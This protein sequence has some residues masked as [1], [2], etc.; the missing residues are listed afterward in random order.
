M[1]ILSDMSSISSHDSM[2]PQDDDQTTI[3]MDTA[4]TFN[5]HLYFDGEGNEISY[6]DYLRLYHD[7]EPEVAE[8]EAEEED[9]NEPPW[10]RTPKINQRF[11]LKHPRVILA[12]L[13]FIDLY[14]EIADPKEVFMIRAIPQA[15]INAICSHSSVKDVPPEFKPD[16]NELI[17]RLSRHADISELEW[18]GDEIAN[19]V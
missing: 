9:D 3:T 17:Y 11:I 10:I 7:T 8:P 1:D 5:T 12:F 16:V 19:L 18:G 6:A 4:G 15:V 13:R 2:P 14:N